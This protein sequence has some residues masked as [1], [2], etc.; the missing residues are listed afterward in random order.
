MNRTF[1]LDQ[2]EGGLVRHQN[3]HILLEVRATLHGDDRGDHLGLVVALRLHLDDANVILLGGRH[4][5]RVLDE[6]P[7]A[8]LDAGI[9]LVLLL[10]VTVL[11]ALLGIPDEFLVG[12]SE[13]GGPDQ[14]L[15][16]V[17]VNRDCH[18]V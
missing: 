9:V 8:R 16:V 12:G 1:A 13:G 18:S 6:E 2:L 10:S 5:H 14:L 17:I 4:Q 7:V 15:L 11:L 3:V